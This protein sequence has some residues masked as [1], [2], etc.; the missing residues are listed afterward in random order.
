[1]SIIIYFTLPV[2]DG[3]IPICVLEDSVVIGWTHADA[4][5]D[6]EYSVW[7][8]VEKRENESE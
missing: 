6:V 3:K 4:P 2:V 1:M 7:C 8:F 5:S